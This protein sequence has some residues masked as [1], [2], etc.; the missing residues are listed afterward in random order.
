M[1]CARQASYV[2]G[3]S[4]IRTRGNSRP[5]LVGVIKVP[6]DYAQ[7]AHMTQTAFDMTSPL[8][9]RWDQEDAEFV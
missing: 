9:S 1:S 7:I 6:S 2:L 8:R 5:L 4:C 3:A